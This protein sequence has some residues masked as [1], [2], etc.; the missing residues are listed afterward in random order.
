MLK[1]LLDNGREV[2]VVAGP[3]TASGLDWYQVK[4]L[5]RAAEFADLPF[6]W[7]AATGGDGQPWLAG[8]PFDCPTPPAD[9]AA[10]VALRPLVGLSCFGR[11]DLT[12]A[13][14]LV[15]PEA[16]CGVDM[17][18][19][20]EPEWLGSTCP[21]PAFLI[22]DESRNE[23]FNAVID[24]ALDIT[25]L[26]PGVEPA[27]WIDVEVTGHFDDPAAGTCKGVSTD[28]PVPL[29]ADDVILVCR[30]QFVITAIEPS[31]YLP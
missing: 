3:V 29:A 14:R 13:A 4:P 28:A 17:G 24:P 23:T 19:T 20:I 11:D 12:L 27:D 18:W 10:F 15:K 2:F 21:Q 1:P 25:N 16:T 30:V 9:Y 31:G 26:H 5:D 6:G 7:V 8:E 22:A